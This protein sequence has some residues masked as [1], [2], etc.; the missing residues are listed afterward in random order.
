MEP[1]QNRVGKGRLRYKTKLR[2]TFYWPPSPSMRERFI[3]DASI[4]G[5][6]SS[7]RGYDRAERLRRLRTLIYSAM[8]NHGARS[9]RYI[10][11]VAQTV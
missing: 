3:I 8:Y 6:S 10:E 11:G 2:K 7:E 4:C 5:S 1:A 9:N